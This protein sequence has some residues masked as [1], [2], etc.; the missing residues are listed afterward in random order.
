MGCVLAA[1]FALTIVPRAWA[2]PDTDLYN[3]APGADSENSTSTLLADKFGNLYGTAPQGGAFGFGT[4]F[5]MCAPGINIP[6]PCVGAPNWQ[7]FVLYN[8]KGP[9]AGDGANPHSTLIFGGNYAGRGFTLYG[10][11]YNGGNANSCGG[12]GCGTVFQLCAPAGVGGCGGAGWAESVLH[13]FLGVKDGAHPFAGVITDKAN[14]LYGTTVYGGAKGVCASG[15][16]NLFCG[17]V[18]KM[19]HNNV[20][21]YAEAVIH[22]FAGAPTDGANPYAALCC[23][24]I[25]GI[26]T[27]YGTT[28]IG[29]ANNL[30]TVFKVANVAGYPEAVLYNFCSA[31]G[32]TD[33]ANPYAD[34]IFDANGQMYGTTFHGGIAGGCGGPGCGTVFKLA[35]L[36]VPLYSFFGAPDGANPTAGLMLSANILYGTTF[37]GGIPASCGGP[38]CGTVFQEPV[39]GGPDFVR[40]SFTGSAILP[41]DGANPYGGVIFDPAVPG[42]LLYGTTH[43][44]GQFGFG[45]VY[46]E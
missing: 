44:A 46:S 25:N 37:Y 28:F 35:A 5:I 42:G 30:G 33:G 29:G 4:V 43:E 41:F 22:R 2:Q 27:L 45:I 9:G 1:L 26:A 21:V 34:V 36:P 20:W 17:T 15:G 19:H 7:E 16:V 8:F 40:Y 32:C 10:T 24:T 31:G 12:T 14:N 11:T 18:F 3:F 6:A 39:G 38:G 13:Q 23:N